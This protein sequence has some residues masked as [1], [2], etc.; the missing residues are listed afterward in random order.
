MKILG[1]P[2]HIM[3]IHFPSALLPMD[4]VCSLLGYYTD[5]SSFTDASFFAMAGAVVFG[6]LAIITGTFDLIGLVDN[7]PLALK[8]ALVHGGINATVIITYSILAFRAWKEFPALTQDG[9]GVL[10][11]KACLITFM[12]VGNYLGGSLILKHRVGLENG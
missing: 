1:H 2:L 9:V 8:K 10:I 7:K 3:L 11:F 5:N 12:I 6:G 4:L